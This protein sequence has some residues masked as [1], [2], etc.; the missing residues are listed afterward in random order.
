MPTHRYNVLAASS[1]AALAAAMICVPLGLVRGGLGLIIGL[2]WIL[3]FLG[4]AI[5]PAITG[6]NVTIVWLYI[7]IADGMSIARVWARRYSK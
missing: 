2:I 3:L 5:V 6:L 7:G 4:G 1:L